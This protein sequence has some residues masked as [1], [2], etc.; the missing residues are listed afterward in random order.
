MPNAI[1]KKP[2]SSTS[3][4]PESGRGSAVSVVDLS[5]GGRGVS[6]LF[7]QLPLDQVI[8]VL[9][10]ALRSCYY[11]YI[12]IFAESTLTLKKYERGYAT[13]VQ[14]YRHLTAGAVDAVDE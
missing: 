1:M 11:E 4:G 12:S 2:I 14:D 5:T 8:T 7:L 6:G 9:L 13:K 3:P 10:V